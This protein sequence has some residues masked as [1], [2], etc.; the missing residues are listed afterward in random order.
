MRQQDKRVSLSG[1]AKKTDCPAVPNLLDITVDDREIKDMVP[2][3]QQGFGWRV[4]ESAGARRRVAIRQRLMRRV[5]TCI[6]GVIV[7]AA[8]SVSAAD[9]W[10]SFLGPNNQTVA[11]HPNLPES[12]ST[13]EN[14]AWK[15]AI[16]GLGWSSPI[17]WD[18]RVF[19]TSVISDG[20]VEKP[21]GGLY[22]GGERD[23][24]T[25]AHHWRM[26]AIDLNGGAILWEREL[27]SS[28]PA[29]EHH[30]KNTFASE[31][32]VT[33]GGQLY[34]RFGNVGI[35]CLDMNGSL[36]WSVKTPVRKM[37]NGWGTA[38]SP[39]LHDGRLYVVDDNDEQSYIVALSAETGTE[40]WRTNRDEGSNWST[41]F[42]W[43]NELRTEIVTTG[44]NKV[45]SYDLDGNLLW[46]L[47]GM[48][49]ITVPTPF[50]EFGIL[51]LS[52]GYVGD[53][54]RPVFAIRPGASGDISLGDAKLSNEF[55]VWSQPQAAPY[56]TSPLIY[57]AYYYTLLDRGMM[58]AHDARTGEV[59]Y[60]RKRI[61]VGE[62]FTSSP[63]AYHDKI[64]ALSEEG[65]TY[66]IRAGPEFEVLAENFLDE[67]TMATPA[68]VGDSLIIRTT[69]HLYKI[70]K[71]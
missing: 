4:R 58:T 26:Y 43:K 67:F 33:D 5:S 48:S 6:L 50:A 46:E 30:V 28:K 55:V 27:H 24:P 1:Q 19:V 52:S 14:V 63:W 68:I 40:I 56:N 22:R 23:I 41:P 69:G 13:T 37:R 34:V 8:A 17:V 54:Q 36:L 29:S 45:R 61:K 70:R 71:Q 11:N 9:N 59:V 47:T 18:D 66:V 10:P 62:G 57:D 3:S 38:S 35:F 20:D 42:I 12:W 44:T 2:V 53:Q 15:T 25:D 60:D 39:A 49:S 64:F 16:P 51:Y 65:T 7:G 32:P 21:I 31:T